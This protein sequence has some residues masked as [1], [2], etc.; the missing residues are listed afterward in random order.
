MSP[1]P[2][3]TD[4]HDVMAAA[5]IDTILTDIRGR[6]GIGNELEEI[7]NGPGGGEWFREELK[8]VVKSVLTGQA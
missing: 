6:R 8:E 3:S 4:Q 5:I 1:Q 7:E 2:D